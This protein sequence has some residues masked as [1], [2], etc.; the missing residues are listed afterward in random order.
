MTVRMHQAMRRLP[1]TTLGR[2]LTVLLAIL[3]GLGALA[4]LAGRPLQARQGAVVGQNLMVRGYIAA[5]VGGRDDAGV[6]SRT[7]P[8]RDVYIP[9][10]DVYLAEPNGAAAVTKPVRTDLSGRFTLYADKPGKYQICWKAAGFIAACHQQ[11][12]GVGGAPAFVSTLR[13]QVERKNNFVVLVGQVRMADGSLPRALDPLGNVNAF[14]VATLLDGARATLYT[15]NVNNFGDYLIPQVPIRSPV[16]VQARIEKG[17]VEQAIFKEAEL[18]RDALHQVDLRIDNT[19]PRIEPLVAL[20]AATGARVQVAAPGSKILFKAVATDRDGDALTYRWQLTNGAGTLSASNAPTTSWQLPPGKGQYGITLIA[21]DGKGGYAKSDFLLRADTGGVPFSGIVRDNA[22]VAVPMATVEIGGV[23][24]ASDASGMFSL[25]VAQANRYVFNIRKPGFAFYSKIYD[26]GI[27]GGAWALTRATVQTVDPTQ[28]I[29]VVNQRRP[30]D[31]PGPGSA[32]LD[33]KTY[34]AAA[35]LQWQDGKGNTVFPDPRAETGALRQVGIGAAPALNRARLAAPLQHRRGTCGAGMAVSIPANSLVD[36]RGNPPVGMVQVSVSTVDLMSPE[37]MPGDYTVK[38]PNNDT[39]VMESFGA[40]S[41]DISAGGTRY[42]LKPGTLATVRI[43]VDGAQ[44]AAGG[45]LPPTIPILFYD[46]R[47]GV[48]FEEGSAPLLGTGAGRMYEA[49]VKHFSTIN[50][51]TLKQNQACIRVLSPQPGMPANYNLEVTVPQASGNAP[52]V[53]TQQMNNAAPSEHVVFNLPT[54]TNVVLVASPVGPN[55]TPYGVYIVNTGQPQNPTSPNMPAGPPYTACSTQVTLTQQAIPTAPLVGEFLHGITIFSAANIDEL[56]PANPTQATIKAAIDQ[57]TTDYYAH[58][59]PRQKRSTLAAFKQTNGFTDSSSNPLPGV[60]NAKYANSGDLGFGRDMYCKKQTA[61][62]G[63]VDYACFV[64]NYGD[65]TTADQQDAIDTTNPAAPIVA[66]VAMEFSRIES[67]SGTPVEFD[68]A[69]AVK[70]AVKFYVYNSAG[71]Q[72]LKAANL[73]GKGAR[74]VPQLCMACHGGALPLA[75]QVVN[76][77]PVPVFNSRDSVKLGSVFVPFDLRY[78]TFPPA[79]NDKAN[80]GVQARFKQLNQEIVAGVAQAAGNLSVKDVIDE[81]YAGGVATQREAFSVAGWR[82]PAAPEPAKAAFYGGMVS[83]SCRMCHTAQ[84]APAIR[85][86]T[87][88][89]FLAKLSEVGTRVCIQHVMPHAARTHEI[90]W[91][92]ADPT[93]VLPATVPNMAAQLQIFGTQFG[94]AADWVG[95]GGSAPAFRCGTSFTSGGLTPQSFY[96]QQIQPLWSGVYGCIGCHSGQTGPAG[97][98]LGAGFS[99]GNL[100]GVASTEVPSMLRV[101]KFDTA[102]S[103]LFHKVV[104]DHGAVGGSGARMPPGCSGNSCVSA[105]DI[106]KLQNWINT[107]GADGP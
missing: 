51:D 92:I 36:S 45:P 55:T 56:N 73:D 30:T 50:G 4:T 48:W 42:N 12:I 61:S 11:V 77:Q 22:G 15:A 33:W 98:G 104:G 14:A 16:F 28:P 76:G 32:R 54:N 7:L 53:R 19:P 106:A 41:I 59:D 27:A 99:Y 80:P 44:L 97:L 1:Q 101:K 83:N 95:S 3:V 89:G 57:A 5:R 60:V 8:A 72:F 21:W 6:P 62:D 2:T 34:P 107:R 105:S 94:P 71:D 35:V 65:V 10:V 23:T 46:E 69:T 74:P 18:E 29:N 90:F 24:A 63:L 13:M 93:V 31:C 66:T 43:P 96:Q 100:V 17:E 26:R 64:S 85:F 84:L 78:F 86:D 39:R 38:L 25:R 82:A 37:Q 81:M 40:G 75:Q 20:D 91:G 103:Y 70:R 102:N 49:K 87:A 9:G 58:V 88:S 67:P 52:L 79:P 68:D 47:N